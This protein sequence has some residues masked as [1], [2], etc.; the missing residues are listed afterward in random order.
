M[1]LTEDI[2]KGIAARRMKDDPLFREVIDGI[3]GDLHSAWERSPTTDAREAIWTK[4][5]GVSLFEAALDGVINNGRV[6]EKHAEDLKKRTT[7]NGP[8]S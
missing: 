5:Q 8:A 3:R 7:G 4:L 2:A 1:N 6:A